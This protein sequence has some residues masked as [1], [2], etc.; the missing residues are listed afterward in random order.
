MSKPPVSQ[1]PGRI[2][3]GWYIVAAVLLIT[4]TTSGLAFY[5]L[6]ILLAAF[7]AERNFPVGVASGATA[8]FFI[9]GGLG[10]LV[11]GR[12]VDR[13]D[14]R[15]VI[16]TS[17]SI[18]ALSLAS[19]GLIY[20]VAHLYVFHAVFGFCHGA[21][22]LVPVT[23]LI[24]RWFN[25][26]RALAFSIGSTGLSLGGLFITPFVAL[27][28]ANWGLAGA[29]PFMGLAFFAGIVPV[30]LMVLRPSPQAMGLEP[31]GARN[32][33]AGASAPPPAA[34]YR[35]ARRSGFFYAV[36]LAYLFLLGAQ[37]AGI[38]HLYRLANMRAGIET[39]ALAIAALAGSST[40]GRL[41]G[42]GVLLKVRSRTFAL[43]LMGVQA[44]ALALLALATESTFIVAGAILFGLTTGNSLM[45]HP[46]LLAE[47]FGTR[48]YG[49]IYSTSQLVTMLGVA[50]GPV[51]VGYM[52]EA[53]T[54]YTLPFLAIAAATLI[55]LMILRMFGR[56]P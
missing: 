27:A 42:G 10:G 52:F 9:A 18:G 53:A 3:Y 14:P 30:S 32:T 40:T 12:L 43:Y 38:A 13:I 46:L 7:I 6:A 35:E 39:A 1:P 44:A 54:D 41:I 28:I 19:V 51:A 17:A 11:A 55:G 34:S 24:A 4:A 16:A 29:A 36:S 2:F 56:E 5:N 48:D 45:M 31:D 26:R 49:R 25:E 37:V 47:R 21:N 22:G 33:A 50:G 8:T 15:I 23:T 20:E